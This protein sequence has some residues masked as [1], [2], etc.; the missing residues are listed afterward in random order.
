MSP[1]LPRFDSATLLLDGADAEARV[2]APF[3]WDERVM[4]WRAPAWSYRQVVSP[5]VHA[6]TPD[7]DHARSYHRF[8]LPTRTHRHARTHGRRRRPARTTRRPLRL[9][10]RDART[11]RRVSF[12]L[13]GC[14]PARGAE[15]RGARGLRAR[16]R[17]LQKF[18]AREGNRTEFSAR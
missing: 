4:R 5:L 17:H 13:H 7:A 16:A 18:S 14:P 2:P 12:R 9:P 10:A 6:T 8:R 3:R 1:L 15:R 11:R